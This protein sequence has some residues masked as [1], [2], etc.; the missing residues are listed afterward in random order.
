MR[1]KIDLNSIGT[2]EKDDSGSI[3]FG[4]YLVKIEDTIDEILLVSFEAE[5]QII[6]SMKDS[7]DF[8]DNLT[9]DQKRI[10]SVYF[11]QSGRII[12]F[13]YVRHLYD[14]IVRESDL[15]LPPLPP[16]VFKS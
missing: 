10:V 7:D 14:M 11:N 9:E 5:Y 4:Q 12:L 15:F 13:P 16:I 3:I 6:L 1:W 2:G 8:K